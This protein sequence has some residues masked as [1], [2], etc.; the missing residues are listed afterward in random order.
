ML[1][2]VIDW[3]ALLNYEV[4]CQRAKAEGTAPVEVPANRFAQL[5]DISRKRGGWGK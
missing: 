2:L 4:Y 1:R 5:Q 3:A